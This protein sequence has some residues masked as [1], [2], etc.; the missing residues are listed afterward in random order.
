[1]LPPSSG[2]KNKLRFPPAFTLVSCLAYSSTLE[3]EVICFCETS[4]DF[5]R[6]T[7]PYFPEDIV[8]HN[9]CCE[10]LNSYIEQMS[11][12]RRLECKWEDVKMDVEETVWECVDWI[13]LDQNRDQCRAFVNTVTKSRVP[14]KAGNFLIRWATAIFSERA[15]LLELVKGDHACRSVRKFHSGK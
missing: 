1:M 12:H 8:L 4:V 9:H 5:Q 6:T 2:S 13:H 15:L 3:I 10:N 11:S 14:R 7:R